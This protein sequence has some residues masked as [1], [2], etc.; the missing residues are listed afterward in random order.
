MKKFELKLQILFSPAKI[1]NIFFL[2]D[3]RELEVL[4][5]YYLKETTKA[6]TYINWFQ[7]A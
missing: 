7:M 4:F 2:N 5:F 3:Q 6:F 1:F